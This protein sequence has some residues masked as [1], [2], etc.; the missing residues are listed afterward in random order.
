[1]PALLV[2]A[3]ATPAPAADVTESGVDAGGDRAGAGQYDANYA[4]KNPAA[5]AALYA[6]DGVLVAPSGSIVRVGRLSRPIM[7]T[8]SPAVPEPCDQSCRSACPGQWWVWPYPIYRRCAGRAWQSSR[9]ARQHRRGLSTRRRWMAHAPRRTERAGVGRPI[10]G[11][12]TAC[13]FDA[14]IF[15]RR[16]FKAQNRL[17]LATCS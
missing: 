8:A 11:S 15:A 2:G 14:K 4:A 17:V 3:T 12:D 1:M 16:N 7:P 10:D 5:M 13:R 6:S 9:R